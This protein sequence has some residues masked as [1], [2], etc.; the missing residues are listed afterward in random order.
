LVTVRVVS[1]PLFIGNDHQHGTSPTVSMIKQTKGGFIM[2][3]TPNDWEE[4]T[5]L[6]TPLR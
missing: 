2:T 3:A 6:Y 4:M 1:L 5:E